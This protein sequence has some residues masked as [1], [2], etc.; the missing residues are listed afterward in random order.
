M[1]AE[2]SQ[3]AGSSDTALP[4]LPDTNSLMKKMGLTFR[5]DLNGLKKTIQGGQAASKH[6]RGPSHPPPPPPVAPQSQQGT[7]SNGFQ[8]QG[9]NANLSLCLHTL[10]SLGRLSLEVFS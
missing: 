10:R 9:S 1:T 5:R 6:K 7:S 2:S 4:F 8:S 3:A